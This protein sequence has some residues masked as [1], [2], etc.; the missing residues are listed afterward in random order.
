MIVITYDLEDDKKRNKLFKLLKNYGQHV[1][2]SVFECDL[3]NTKLTQ[4]GLALDKFDF[5]DGDSIIIYSICEEFQR[6]IKT[7]GNSNVRIN[8]LNLIY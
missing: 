5:D 2:Y 1:Q 3:S 4:L 6:K 7:I 8:D